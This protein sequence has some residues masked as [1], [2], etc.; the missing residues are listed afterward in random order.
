MSY[1]NYPNL[2]NAVSR[3]IN[4][5]INPPVSIICFLRDECRSLQLLSATN[6]E[7]K[8]A[9]LWAT[10]RLWLLRVLVQEYRPRFYTSILYTARKHVLRCS[11]GLSDR[12]YGVHWVHNN[13]FAINSVT[14][15]VTCFISFGTPTECL[16]K[17]MP[18]LLNVDIR[19]I[20]FCL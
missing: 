13:L 14:C 11:S 17:E 18:V 20:L 19:N 10:L 4:Q 2:R 6:W 12:Y 16:C 15:P 7:A 9:E 3:W 1:E 5:S 8:L